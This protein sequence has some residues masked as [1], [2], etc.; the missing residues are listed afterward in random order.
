MDCECGGGDPGSG[1]VVLEQKADPVSRLATTVLEVFIALVVAVVLLELSVGSFFVTEALG[2]VCF[3]WIGFLRR[4][5]PQTTVPRGGIVSALTLMIVAVVLLRVLQFRRKPLFDTSA[6]ASHHHDGAASC[7]GTWAVRVLLATMLLFPAGMAFTGFCR[8]VVWFAATDSA[9]RHSGREAAARSHAKNQLKHVGLSMHIF[10]EEHGEF[11]GGG[12]FSESGEG[13]H[14]WATSLLPYMQDDELVALHKSLKTDQAWDSVVNANQMRTLIPGL[15]GP[16]MPKATWADDRGFAATHFSA[17]SW[18][19]GPNSSLAIR[20]IRDGTTNTLM[21]G[22]IRDQIPA[23]GDP[24]NWRDPTR[25]LNSPGA[26]GSMHIG[27]VQFLL[28]DGSV[29]A[30]SENIDATTMR[31]ISSPDGGEPVGAF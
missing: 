7:R 25:R 22:Q 23:W 3:G 18:L 31:A 5:V 15:I 8:S 13:L 26:F 21:V 4:V 14:S 19:M 17:N 20:D 29:R 1:H 24:V 28:A 6:E 11:P 2:R 10:H 30:I 12:T 16:S 9:M 27:V